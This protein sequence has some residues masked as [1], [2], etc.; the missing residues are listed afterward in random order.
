MQSRGSG[1]GV[2]ERKVGIGGKNGGEGEWGR[3]KVGDGAR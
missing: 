3:G 2:K 1:R